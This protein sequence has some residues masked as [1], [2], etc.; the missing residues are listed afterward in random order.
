MATITTEQELRDAIAASDPDLSVANNITLTLPNTI[1]YNAELKANDYV[2]TW[3]TTQNGPMFSV[4]NG[5][6]LAIENIILD[7]SGN[8]VTLISVQASTAEI[9]AGAVLR[10]SSTTVATPAIA[11]GTSANLG[12]GGT[13]LMT[14][15][16]ITGML[17]DSA[18]SCW[19]GTITMSG[20]AAIAQNQAYG[21]YLQGGT[22]NM[23]GNAGISENVAA[24]LGAGVRA[25]ANSEINMG[26]AA[27][28]APRISA[29]SST[30]NSGGG[31]WLAGTSI[32]NMNYGASISGNSAAGVA[33]GVGLN[34]STL[35][36]RGNSVISGNI[37][38]GAITLNASGG[39]VYG[40]T[41]V[42]VNMADNAS[43]SANRTTSTNN[44][45]GGG[46]FLQFGSAGSTFTM[47]GNASITGNSSTAFCG[48]LYI[49]EN[50]TA[51]LSDQSRIA[52]NS[53]GTDFHGVC[54]SGTLQ[55]SQN[56][57]IEDGL[58][59]NSLPAAPVIVGALGENAS[60]QLG[61]TPYVAPENIPVVAAVKGAGYAALTDTDSAAFRAP[62][63]FPQ[64]TPIYLNAD[65]N[66]VLIGL[67]VRFEAASFT[68]KR[69]SS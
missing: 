15:G 63:S 39:G 68:I 12:V 28:D 44:S 5:A 61:S 41:G 25:T 56:V 46:V 67:I 50:I 32:L 51:T 49:D 69:I 20:D 53:A 35:S 10:N 27:G 6:T 42:Q 3:N 13:F 43:I 29:N 1:N 47:S 54:N 37:S 8:S 30:N 17:Q 52:N 34:N 26:L 14:G 31:V 24:R 64:G 59:V 16:L 65:S 9:R 48:G 7:G 23:S 4:V 18:V 19:G 38:T 57:R 66:Q 60:I 2:L 36:M 21:I 45:V 40:T 55:L 62:A 58:Y 11:I 22:L 33:G